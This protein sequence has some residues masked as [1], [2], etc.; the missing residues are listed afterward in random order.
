MTGPLLA[1]VGAVGGLIVGAAFVYF[2]LRGRTSDQAVVAREDADRAVAQA[3]AQAKELVLEAKDEA[4]KIRGAAEQDARE[5]RTELQRQ[6]RRI[7]QKEENLDNRAEALER[8]ER[9]LG[10]REQ[11]IE[12]RRSEIDEL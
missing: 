8:R 3:Q 12:G 9:Q 4:H 5:R 1:V 11:E 7:V 10:Q 2:W 6:E